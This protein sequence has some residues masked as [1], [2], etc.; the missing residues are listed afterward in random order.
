MKKY[1]LF[2]FLFLP[3]SLFGQDWGRIVQEYGAGVCKIE[4]RSGKSVLASGTG[5]A[6]DGEGL[7]MTNSHVIAEAESN[8]NL[9]IYLAFSQA[10]DGETWYKADPLVHSPQEDLALLHIERDTPVYFEFSTAD[11]PELMT[12]I[13]IMGY[14]LGQGYKST[15]G[16]IQAFQK[17]YGIGYMYDLSAGVDPGSS[18]GPVLGKDG[19]I[20]GV[21]TAHIA[22]RNFNFALPLTAVRGFVERADDPEL[23]SLTS[24]PAGARVYVND[25]FYGETPLT[26]SLYGSKLDLRLEADSYVAREETLSPGLE[27]NELNIL[28]EKDVPPKVLVTIDSRPEGATIWVDNNE[29]GQAPVQFEAEP[30]S[31][32][33]VLGKLKRKKDIFE[34]FQIE[35]EAEQTIILDF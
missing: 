26:L 25:R 35:E 22:G 3:L 34:T 2:L 21:V 24:E 18:G 19:K 17:V 32:I 27:Q 7:V 14:P 33:R 29:L 8:D 6:I 13:L 20:L 4:I 15:P 23:L 5:F 10:D 30:S 9:D 16:F 1:L 28:L 11:D 31:R 12:E